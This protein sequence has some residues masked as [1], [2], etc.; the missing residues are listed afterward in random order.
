MSA[1]SL[2][3]ASSADVR[4]SSDYLPNVAMPKWKAALLLGAPLAVALGI[5]YKYGGSRKISSLDDGEEQSGSKSLSTVV[6]AESRVQGSKTDSGRSLAAAVSTKDEGNLLLKRGKLD[7]A[8]AAYSRAIDQCPQIHEINDPAEVKSRAAELAKIFQNRA[9]AYGKSG[10]LSSSLS[11]CDEAIRLDPSYAR[12]WSRRSRVRELTGDLAESLDDLTACCI[13]DEFRKEDN[14][15]AVDR[16]LK[17]FGEKEAKATFETRPKFVPSNQF[18]RTYF[19]AFAKD[20]LFSAA[21]STRFDDDRNFES[22]AADSSQTS[23]SSSSSSPFLTARRM[24][25]KGENLEKVIPL[26]QKEI[27]LP[28]TPFRRE[29][30][31]LKATFLLLRGSAHEA[32]DDLNAL[33]SSPTPKTASEGDAGDSNYDIDVKV[34]ALIKRGG[35]RMQICPAD[36]AALENES[37]SDFLAAEKLDDL[38]SD[39]FHHRGQLNLLLDKKEDACKDFGRCVDL[40]PQFA[41]AQVQN[42]YT[43]FRH[44]KALLSN[45]D[46]SDLASL[47]SSLTAATKKTFNDLLNTFPDCAEGWALYGQILLDERQ[48]KEADLMFR[49]ALQLEPD[50]GNVW[51]HRGLCRLQ[52][53]YSGMDRKSADSLPTPDSCRGFLEEA[54]RV[55]PMCEFAYETLG[56]VEVKNGRLEKASALFEKA[57]EFAKTE[58]EMAHLV[59]LNAATKAQINASRKLGIRLA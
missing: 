16:L 51:V 56:T 17:A 43:Q 39:V 44:Q 42:A 8:I 30:S 41:L 31:L 12:A 45:E 23:L 55:D 20:P 53:D 36:G 49:R 37:M 19:A 15:V 1:A 57:I 59:S 40:Q 28:S 27:E 7:D 6:A 38:N 3:V 46:D 24:V 10:D 11:D 4:I 26:C 18:V 35:L 14:L 33:I 2:S 52:W 32:L 48:F 47:N 13:L 54:L 25:I 34:N 21:H 22:T 58:T 50:N 9:F 29:A 5:Y